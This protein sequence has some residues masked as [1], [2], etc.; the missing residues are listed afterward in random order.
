MMGWNRK[1]IDKPLPL[2][3]FPYLRW[4]ISF[5]VLCI[6]LLL[7]YFF[8][9][10][11]IIYDDYILLSSPLILFFSLFVVQLY[12]YAKYVQDYRFRIEHLHAIKEKWN[13]WGSRYISVLDCK[14]YLPDRLD[15]TSLLD[16][17]IEIKYGLTSRIDYFRW[18]TDNWLSVFIEITADID[19]HALPYDI[20]KEFIIITDCLEDGFEQLEN[21]FFTALEKTNM[22]KQR[23]PLRIV[24]A[25]SFE[26]LNSWLK[27]TEEKIF[28]VIIMQFNGGEDYSDGLVS[29]LFAADDVVR[30]YKLNEIAR[31]CRPMVVKNNSFEKDMDIFIDTQKVAL[32][33][34][35]LTGDC[36]H[37]LSMNSN[38][39]QCFDTKES[40]LQV[41]NI[42]VL[43]RIFGVPGINSVW[44]TAALTVSL[45][46]YKQSEQLMMA[47]FNDDWI[48]ATVCTAREHEIRK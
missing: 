39:L 9:D 41:E 5:M 23:Y 7:I 31:I 27:V 44:L 4:F 36:A 45:V 29:F 40:Q 8:L 12:F 22:L 10:K 48:I 1:Y 15:A 32:E 20:E 16:N 46:T 26:Q 14:L 30:K 25:M 42:Q 38:I 3:A 47:G 18:R 2:L 17:A 13:A 19:I 35:G 11:K 37:L 33:A 34:K 21:D 28:I 6:C 24:P 43:E